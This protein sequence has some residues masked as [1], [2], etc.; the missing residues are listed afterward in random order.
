[1]KNIFLELPYDEIFPYFLKQ[2][3]GLHLNIS[4]IEYVVTNALTVNRWIDHELKQITVETSCHKDCS[5]CCFLNVDTFAHERILILAFMPLLI[6]Q[7]HIWEIISFQIKEWERQFKIL[8][9]KH[10]LD[11]FVLNKD[12]YQL[13]IK[14]YEKAKIPCPFLLQNECFIYTVRPIVCRT[15]LVSSSPEQ[16]AK[17]GQQIIKPQGSDI[18]KSRSITILEKYD[19]EFFHDFN[20]PSIQPLGYYFSEHLSQIN[21]MLTAI[22]KYSQMIPVDN[23]PVCSHPN[24]IHIP[25]SVQKNHPHWPVYQF[26]EKCFKRID[27]IDRLSSNYFQLS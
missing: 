20:E 25:V 17:I 21:N 6:H 7:S 19:K 13:M 24:F 23:R 22:E 26:L 12:N 1:M 10:K 27:T 4:E 18:I 15:Y 14:V 5:H 3:I 11:N 9:S 16:C 2:Y 8:L